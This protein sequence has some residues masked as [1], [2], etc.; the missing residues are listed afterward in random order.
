M[1]VVFG[2]VLKNS[3]SILGRLANICLADQI[4]ITDVQYILIVLKL[5]PAIYACGW[6][7]LVQM[8]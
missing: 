2:L 8:K 5:V 7:D 3:E 6:Q 4:L 1:L